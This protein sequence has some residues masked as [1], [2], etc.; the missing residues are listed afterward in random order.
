VFLYLFTGPNG[1]EREI[2][3]KVQE[4]RNCERCGKDAQFLT[5]IFGTEPAP[6]VTGWEGLETLQ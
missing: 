4:I 1:N 5:Y 2:E 3:T 6:A